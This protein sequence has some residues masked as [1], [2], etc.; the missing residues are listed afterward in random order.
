MA[1]GLQPDSTRTITIHVDDTAISGLIE[2]VI[3]FVFADGQIRSVAVAGIVV[4][5]S[6]R[7]VPT[8]ALAN[9]NL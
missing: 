8:Q 2:C 6:S 7:S 4:S 1:S 9:T 5:V 3:E